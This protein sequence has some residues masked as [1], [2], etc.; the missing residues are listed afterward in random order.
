MKAV[1]SMGAVLVLAACSPAGAP[2]PGESS[3]VPSQAPVQPQ[4]E[5]AIRV[6]GNHFA[7]AS[8][9]PTRLLGVNYASGE[10]ACVLVGFQQGATDARPGPALDYHGQEQPATTGHAAI[11]PE[12]F[13]AAMGAFHS[14]AVRFMVNEMCWLGRSGP[15]VSNPPS[16]PIPQAHYDAAA[17]RAAITTFVDLLHRHGMYAVIA[18]GD[19]PCP[20]RFPDQDG[21]P[22]Y[23]PPGS[24]YSRCDDEQQLMPDADNSPA[25]WSS[26]AATFKD[27]RGVVFELFNEPH[28][29]HKAGVEDPWAC[30]KSGCE[31]PGEN[32]RTAGMQTLVNAIR[33]AGAKQPILVEGLGYGGRPGSVA[34]TD[35]AATGWLDP[36]VRLSDP[37]SP[38]QLALAN[39]IYPETWDAKDPGCPTGDDATCWK[40]NLSPAAVDV[41]LVTTEL[42][43]H[44]CDKASDFM[45]AYMRWADLTEKTATGTRAPAGYLGWTFNADYSCSGGNTTLI[46]DWKGTPNVAGRALSAHLARVR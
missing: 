36:A 45:D 7:D 28:I 40:N 34:S 37:L 29:D 32:W 26:I 20:Y 12:S 39:H 4:T 19:N 38:P 13:V 6:D 14:N 3:K 17:Y 1:V 44:D 18:L 30:W 15:G 8:G 9:H 21:A 22:T 35:Q 42:G 10:G 24:Q 43:Q 46:T 2:P 16:A 23:H 27:D 31:V 33:G 11:P 5:L 25:F 41:P